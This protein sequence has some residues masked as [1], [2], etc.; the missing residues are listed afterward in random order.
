MDNNNK[1]VWSE[2]EK[3]WFQKE[4]K[5]TSFCEGRGHQE[6]E[7]AAT[8][9]VESCATKPSEWAPPCQP[10]RSDHFC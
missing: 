9:V 3:R 7:G 10:P 8:W 2:Q 4:K 6:E 5:H 1:N